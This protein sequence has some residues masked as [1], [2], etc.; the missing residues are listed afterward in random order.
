MGKKNKE[1]RRSKKK[2]RKKH[3]KRDEIMF[4]GKSVGGDF[5]LDLTEYL[6]SYEEFYGEKH[7]FH[8]LDGKVKEEVIDSLI[9][10]KEA[11]GLPPLRENPERYREIIDKAVDAAHEYPQKHPAERLSISGANDVLLDGM[12]VDD[13]RGMAKRLLEKDPEL[14]AVIEKDLQRLAKQGAPVV[15]RIAQA[16]HDFLYPES[17]ERFGESDGLDVTVTTDSK[18]LEDF[19]LS[20]SA[21]ERKKLEQAALDQNLS[22]GEFV[23][24]GIGEQLMRDMGHA[25]PNSGRKYVVNRYLSFLGALYK[26]DEHER[27]EE[28]RTALKRLIK[29]CRIFE[30]PASLFTKLYKETDDFVCQEAGIDIQKYL[31]ED[32][33]EGLLQFSKKDYKK[34]TKTYEDLLKFWYL[35][36]TLPFDCLY[37]GIEAPIQVTKAQFESYKH[38]GFD[39]SEEVFNINLLGYIVNQHHVYT[40][41]LMKYAPRPGDTNAGLG[42]YCLAEKNSN[43]WN[44]TG[45]PTPFVVKWLIDWINDHQTCVKE[46]TKSFGYR[47][48]YKK[49]AKRF[50]IKKP[51]PAPYYTVY[52]KDELIDEEAW[53]RKLR[54]KLSL[55]PRKSPQHQYDVRGAWVCRYLRGPLPLDPRLEK[56]LRRDK[57]RKLFIEEQPDIDTVVHMAKRG[58]PPK[59]KDEWLAILLYWRSDHRRG[60]TD[61]PYIPSVRK[62]GRPK[63]LRDE[64]RAVNE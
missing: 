27:Y 64:G 61:G 6:T 38:E 35:P 37:L 20:F 47:R 46:G 29:E 55:K 24:T 23:K 31:P 34:F 43:G 51:I 28:T 57:R 18:D 52:I 62:S 49:I 16:R 42:S 15:H 53:M 4:R 45:T 10:L 30:I 56:R 50:E 48:E 40:I 17:K 12:S 36:E 8:S 26:A 11:F 9:L 44:L 19:D 63:Y 2:K 13:M 54:Q 1:K 58:I 25:S 39:L 3:G 60:P 7:K 41:F 14:A 32:E 21:D 33:N 59:R 22:V 5:L